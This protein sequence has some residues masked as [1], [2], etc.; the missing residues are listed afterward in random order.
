MNFLFVKKHTFYYFL[1][2][3]NTQAYQRKKP[4]NTAL[5]M[6][7]SFIGSA[8]DSISNQYYLRSAFEK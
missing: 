1:Y 8:A 7:K 3:T 2:V 5:G 4:E 6:K